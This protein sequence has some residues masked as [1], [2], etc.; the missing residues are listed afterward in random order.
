MSIKQV[1]DCYESER[2]AMD[3]K[4]WNP[5]EV[6]AMQRLLAD[7]IRLEDIG[8]GIADVLK[9]AITVISALVKEG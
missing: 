7:E 8:R 6:E 2:L 9:D 4:M 5:N 1:A 3:E